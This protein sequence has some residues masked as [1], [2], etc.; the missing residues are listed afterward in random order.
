MFLYKI[1]FI[2]SMVDCRI[3]IWKHGYFKMTILCDKITMYLLIIMYM[4][5][6]ME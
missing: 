3:Y 2:I 1:Q 6:E 5:N 4:K